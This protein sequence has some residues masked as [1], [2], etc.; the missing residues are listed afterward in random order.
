MNGLA[1]LG[2]WNS[3]VDRPQFVTPSGGGLTISPGH[4]WDLTDD[5]TWA[6]SVGSWDLTEYGTVGISSGGGPN[7]QDVAVFD[8][9]GDYLKITSKNPVTEGYDTSFSLSV[10]AYHTSFNTGNYGN[11]YMGWRGVSASV[12]HF[13]LMYYG[14]TVDSINLQGVKAAVNSSAT[15]IS[16]ATNTWYHV[17]ATWDGTTQKLYVNGSLADSDAN[18][19]TAYNGAIPFIVGSTYY[20]TDGGNAAVQM[21]GRLGML[22]MWD[23]V[24]TADDISYLYNSGNGR[25]YGDL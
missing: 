9:T 17:A 21:L 19:N 8:A 3:P 10:W 23:G 11:Y 18:S 1:P 12:F 13:D 20:V 15:G 2:G 16:E 5:G 14:Y 24:L 7:G 6:D 25:Q 22:G 4:W